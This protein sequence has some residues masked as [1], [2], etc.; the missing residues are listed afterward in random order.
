MTHFFKNTLFSRY[1]VLQL[2]KI[3]IFRTDKAIEKKFDTHVPN[4]YAP[5]LCYG[6]YGL[7]L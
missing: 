7:W 5:E 2:K 1:R 6:E 3:Y 4:M